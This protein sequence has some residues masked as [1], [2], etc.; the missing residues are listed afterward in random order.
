M[1]GIVNRELSKGLR[2]AA[3]AI[4]VTGRIDAAER[5]LAAK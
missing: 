1:K 5:A 3:I 2:I 4:V